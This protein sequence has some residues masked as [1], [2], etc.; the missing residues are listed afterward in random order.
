VVHECSVDDPAV[1]ALLVASRALVAVAARSLADI[2]DIT[3]PQYRALIVLRNHPGIAVTDLAEALDVHPSTATRL[4]DR[5]A[6]KQLI[7]RAQGTQDRRSTELHLAAG[8]RRL[9]ERV[10]DR[11][12]RDLAAIAAKLPD[13]VRS[14][15][16]EALVAFAEA[17]GEPV[18]LDLFGW[19]AAAPS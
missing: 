16:V 10:T 15:A 17:A 8:G 19:E 6:R 2:D 12:R 1:D 7:R 5:L 3:L 18:G 9:I 4:C 14:R 13:D 11:R